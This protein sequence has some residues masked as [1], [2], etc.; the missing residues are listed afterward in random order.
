LKAGVPQGSVLGSLLFLLFIN[1]IAD[2]NQSL[3]RLFADDS[4]LILSSTNPLE[5][6]DRLNLG[7]QVLD[8][9]AKQWLVDFNPQKTEYMVI[10]FQQNINQINL[11]FNSENLNQVDNHKHLGVTISSNGKWA[12]HINNIKRLNKYLS[13]E[14]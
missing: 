4:S 13:L 6:E 5:V 10:S 8:D 2:D 3:V 11:K 9:W 1:D 7:L 12:E 14:N